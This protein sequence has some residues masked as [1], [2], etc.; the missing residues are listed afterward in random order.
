VN[1]HTARGSRS[2]GSAQPRCLRR[3]IR[4][5]PGGW[6]AEHLAASAFVLMLGLAAI[7]W[8]AA[9]GERATPR[10]TPTSGDTPYQFTATAVSTGGVTTAAA[11]I[12]VTLILGAAVIGVLFFNPRNAVRPAVPAAKKG[13]S[14]GCGT[15][16][17][18]TRQSSMAP[19]AV[20]A[21]CIRNSMLFL[22]FFSRSISRSMACCESRPDSTRRSL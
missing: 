13:R 21:T 19:G 10:T 22:D 8:W 12:L 18:S 4:A 2:P 16:L 7:G 17:I 3:M 1:L 6:R 15:S 5:R 14:R 9:P 11:L 20:L